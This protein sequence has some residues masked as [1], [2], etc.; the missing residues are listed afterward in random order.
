[1]SLPANNYTQIFIVFTCLLAGF[2]LHA[3]SLTMDIEG[4]I[5][6]RCEISFNQGN[7]INLSHKRLETLPFELY[8]NQPFLI[9]VSSHNGGL[10]LGS[11]NNNI[12]EDYIF[13]VQIDKTKTRFKSKSKDLT[14]VNKISSF[15]VIPFS[16]T[17]ELRVT[18]ERG[19][20]YAGHYRDT[21][22]IDIIP[23][24]LSTMK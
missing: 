2:N 9:E 16:S 22:E 8:C 21:V 13:E 5:S 1:M 12:V 10:K 20:L 4:R 3:Q 6:N 19:L 24:I 23:S 14:N 7:E 15:G 17:G 18:L 11:E